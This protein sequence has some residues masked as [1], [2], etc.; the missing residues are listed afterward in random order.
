MKITSKVIKDCDDTKW[1][2][3][4]VLE[5]KYTHKKMP[6]TILVRDFI[7]EDYESVLKQLRRAVRA[8]YDEYIKNK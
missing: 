5:L 4:K 8:N 7:E 2:K 1:N 6:W 3:T